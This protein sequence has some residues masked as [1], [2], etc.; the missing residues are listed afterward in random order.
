[1]QHLPGY[2]QEERKEFEPMYPLETRS[3]SPLDVCRE[4]INTEMNWPALEGRLIMEALLKAN[5]RR[6]KAA[7]I[8]GWG[9]TTLWRKMKAYGIEPR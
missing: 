3:L 5:G 9:R 7:E 1:M 2:I 6:K 8:L 4:E